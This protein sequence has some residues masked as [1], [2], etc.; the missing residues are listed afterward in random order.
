MF[1]SNRER[2][3]LS[4]LLESQE[5]VSVQT[6][7]EM[8]DVSQRTVYRELSNIEHSLSS[9]H[10]DLINQRG[11]GYQLQ[12]EQANLAIL[13][14]HL[15]TYN[16][17]VLSVPER[18]RAIII[19]LLLSDIPQTTDYLAALFQVSNGTIQNDLDEIES[20]LD[21]LDISLKRQKF[22][23]IEVTATERTIREVVTSLI[24]GSVEDHV[25]FEY[26][27]MVEAEHLV[28]ASNYFL[29]QI[30]PEAFY[31]TKQVINKNT[32]KWFNKVTDNQLQH[33]MLILALITDRVRNNYLLD[34]LIAIKGTNSEM[35]L[36]AHELVGYI[37]EQLGVS[38]DLNERHFIA[39]QLEGLNYKSSQNIFM[40]EFD[41]QL[42]HQVK[43]L[44][45][46]VSEHSLNNFHLDDR[47]FY[48]LVAHLQATFKRSVKLNHKLDTPVL[49]KINKEYSNLSH[50]LDIAWPEVFPDY[51]LTGD[52]KGYV[53]IHFATSLER[54]PKQKYSIKALVISSSGVGTGKILENRIKRYLPEIEQV[55]VIRLSRLHQVDFAN[56][57]LILSTIYLSDMDYPYRVISPLLS[58]EEIGAIRESIKEIQKQD[59]IVTASIEAENTVGFADLYEQMQL[60][61]KLLDHFDVIKITGEKTI[62]ATLANI[63]QAINSDI[64]ADAQK[65]TDY[66]IERY[67]EVPI[68]IPNSH[69]ALFHTSNAAVNEAYFSIYETDQFYDIL[70]M[71]RETISIN[72][73]LLVL[74]PEPLRESETQLLGL[75]SSSIIENDVNL[76]IYQ[77][78]SYK[79]I[80]QL[81]SSLFVEEIQ[82]YEG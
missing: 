31:I 73:I 79:E 74:A 46:I 35:I 65:V 52:E 41:S 61:K 9:I 22:K 53:I 45:R 47:L 80:Y 48:D 76:D 42:S 33:I 24:Y 66:I 4:V 14:K 11:S 20:E 30:S 56:Y 26:L 50:A 69:I 51:L 5:S 62:E 19:E 12:G 59:K 8:L 15:S 27:N 6:L 2:R 58:E 18:Q 39:K 54:H 68:G 44:I 60:S 1:Y 10:I 77:N 40:E 57:P 3:I 13:K 21:Y 63:I 28:P 23:G 25:F 67:L 72:R 7:S 71:D 64:V 55:D 49:E 78:S 17:D 70:G 81:I 32:K 36:L 29:A 43:E 16:E 75:I 34:E 38:F 82:N 37:S